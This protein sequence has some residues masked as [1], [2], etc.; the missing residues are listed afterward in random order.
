MNRF[1]VDFKYDSAN[2]NHEQWYRE[3][4]KLQSEMKGW[5]IKNVDCV[6]SYP[7]WQFKTG[8]RCY[9]VRGGLLDDDQ[10]LEIHEGVYIFDDMARLAFKLRFGV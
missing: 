10:Y 7:Y 6:E 4:F 1:L 5:L 2:N 8:S 9:I 3:T